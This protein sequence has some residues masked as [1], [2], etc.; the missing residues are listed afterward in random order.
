MTLTPSQH[1]HK[2]QTHDGHLT[3]TTTTVG[4]SVSGEDGGSVVTN[5]TLCLRQLLCQLKY[6]LIGAVKFFQGLGDREIAEKIQRLSA[7]SGRIPTYESLQGSHREWKS[8]L[9]SNSDVS[10]TFMLVGHDWEREREREGGWGGHV[11]RAWTP[12]DAATHVGRQACSAVNEKPPPPPAPREAR[13]P[14]A[15]LITLRLGEGSLLRPTHAR[16]P[17]SRHNKFSR[18]QP[19]AWS[20]P[21]FYISLSPRAL[22]ILHCRIEGPRRSG[23]SP[24]PGHSRIFPCRNFAG[25]CRWSAGFSR[26]SPVSPALSFRHCSILTSIALIGS[27]DLYVKSRPNLFTHSLYARLAIV[28]PSEVTLDAATLG[29]ERRHF[30][31]LRRRES[32]SLPEE[33]RGGCTRSQT[34][35]RHYHVSIHVKSTR[36][37]T[38]LPSTPQQEHHPPGCRTG[39]A[40]PRADFI[41]NSLYTLFLVR[42]VAATASHTGVTGQ[43]ERNRPRYTCKP[44]GYTATESNIPR[45]NKK[46]LNMFS[47]EFPRCGANLKWDYKSEIVKVNQGLS[48]QHYRLVTNYTIEINT[49]FLLARAHD[50]HS[51]MTWSLREAMMRVRGYWRGRAIP[52]SISRHSDANEKISFTSVDLCHENQRRN[53]RGMGDPRENPPTS[54]IVLH[55]S[56]LGKSGS[57]WWEASRLTAQ[58][59]RPPRSNGL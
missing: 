37:H 58:P 22:T 27:Q 41:T 24:R 16:P 29:V 55:D 34:L 3:K 53:A 2:H 40:K 23:F 51:S 12:V 50:Y 39:V 47:N 5:F 7:S 6:V 14:H 26:G 49:L 48:F 38:S 52:G 59:P 45:L 25:R 56:H 32:C 44:Q 30:S 36:P 31:F 1:R 10:G 17:C 8:V 57:P 21:A 18:E 46:A 35:I 4:P 28:R 20:A 43:R 42:E 15:V 19:P 13:R 9:P 33:Q 11:G 54:R